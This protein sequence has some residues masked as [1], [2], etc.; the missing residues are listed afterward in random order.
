MTTNDFVE[1]VRKKNHRMHNAIANNVVEGNQI[2]E[3]GKFNPFT[4]EEIRE[5]LRALEVQDLVYRDEEGNW[6]LS[7]TGADPREF[8]TTPSQYELGLSF[9]QSVIVHA[10][11]HRGCASTTHEIKCKLH[12]WGYAIQYLTL[13][14]AINQLL[15]YR[16]IKRLDFP[17]KKCQTLA[18]EIIFTVDP[19]TLI[20]QAQ[21][22]YQNRFFKG[23]EKVSIKQLQTQT[24]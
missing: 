10:L 1:E 20:E 2:I 7:D 11:K 5:R 24:H 4:V 23:G 6:Y 15:K 13:W 19:F 18:V 9:T 17:T 14:K 12:D 16:I 8:P 21:Y 22:Y 3:G